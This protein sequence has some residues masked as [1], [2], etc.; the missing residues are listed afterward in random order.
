MR[1][2]QDILLFWDLSFS[3]G[4]GPKIKASGRATL[5]DIL[6]VMCVCAQPQPPAPARPSPSSGTTSTGFV[7]RV[8]LA[9]ISFL[10]LAP[11]Q[12]VALAPSEERGTYLT[13]CSGETAEA[14][15]HRP[16]VHPVTRAPVHQAS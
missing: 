2:N 3:P 10:L 15:A 13:H 9:A 8:W 1:L 14:V 6:V 5:D 11:V 4:Q 16:V 12:A 7:A